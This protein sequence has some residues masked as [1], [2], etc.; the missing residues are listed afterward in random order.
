MSS[1][2]EWVKARR[3]RAAAK[4]AAAGRDS[5]AAAAAA[6]A[7]LTVWTTENDASILGDLD[8]LRMQRAAS[9]LAAEASTPEGEESD[10]E[11]EEVC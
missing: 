7:A 4:N 1:H 10:E 5:S 11:D 8:S 6:A 3:A 9:K 2:F